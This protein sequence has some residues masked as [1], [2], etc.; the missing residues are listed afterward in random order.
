MVTVADNRYRR[1]RRVSRLVM[2]QAFV[3][4]PVVGLIELS[5]GTGWG[6]ALISLAAMTVA[7]RCW[8]VMPWA[9]VGLGWRVL[10]LAVVIGERA[11]L[12]VLA[13]RPDRPVDLGDVA[14]SLIILTVALFR[15]GPVVVARTWRAGDPGRSVHLRF[16]LGGGRFVIGQGGPRPLNQHHP[17][18]A[19]RAALDI[20][21]LTGGRRA[22]G[23]LPA[24]LDRYAIYGAPVYAP[25]SGRVRFAVDDR[26]DAPIG[27]PDPAHAPGNHVW[28]EADG[29]RILLAHLQ[30]GSVA[31]RTGEPVEA[32]ARLGLVGNS[33]NST[34]P[35]LHLHAE[36]TADDG[37]VVPVHLLFDAPED[38]RERR[39]NDVVRRDRE[40]SR[41]R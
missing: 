27:R 17:V 37:G 25:V 40:E 1:A 36:A 2:V 23:L 32:G 22:R 4:G 29:I 13:F 9:L 8:R 14:I 28:I 33:G 30:P 10:P 21:G 7:V 20:L 12:A 11:A 6:W 18:V 16:P 15:Y 24:E 26:P 5:G 41:C 35:H 31:V 19:Q 38:G 39:R 34:E 3:L